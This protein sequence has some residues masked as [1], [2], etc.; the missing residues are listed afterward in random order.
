MKT[1]YRLS[2][3]IE[4]SLIV[5]FVTL[6]AVSQVEGSSGILDGKKFVGPTGEIGKKAD[7]NDTLSFREGKFISA[8]CEQ[9]GFESSYYKTTI[10]GD[11]IHFEAKTISSTHG[12][13]VWNG[14]LKGDIIEVTYRWTKK[15]WFWTIERSYWFK[16]S[17]EK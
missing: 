13:I 8:S 2:K 10:D 12:S 14:T 15:R 9:Y 4:F 16:G 7:H 11:V 17:L 6:W 3:V 5:F 1:P